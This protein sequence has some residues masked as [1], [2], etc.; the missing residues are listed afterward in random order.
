MSSRRGGGGSV[1]G[2]HFRAKKSREGGKDCAGLLL[3]GVLVV[4]V[5]SVAHL[6][7]LEVALGGST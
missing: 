1:G 5:K 4:L 3:A 6:Q 7:T 2:A